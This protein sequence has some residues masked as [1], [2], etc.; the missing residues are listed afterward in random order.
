ME[1]FDE[2]KIVLSEKGQDYLEPE[3]RDWIVKLMFLSDITKHLN[4]LSLFLQDAGKTVMD[5]YDTWKAFIAKLAVY[6]SDIKT[7]FSVTS[8]LFEATYLQFILP[9]LLIFRCACKH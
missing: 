2:I 7:V 4:D 9:T 5:L 8:N 3:D 6:S 1:C